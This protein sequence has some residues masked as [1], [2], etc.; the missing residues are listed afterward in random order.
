MGKF[1]IRALSGPIKGKSFSFRKGLKIG[2]SKGE[3]LLPDRLVSDLHAEIAF[4][5]KQF[6]IVDRG[7]KNKIFM[8]GKRLEKS[9]LQIGSKFKIGLTEF[10][11]EVQKSPEQI[12]LDFMKSNIDSIE[13]R[14][15]RLEPF[16]KALRLECVSGLDRGKEFLLLYGPRFFGSGSVEFPLFDESI[17]KKAFAF[18]PEGSKILFLSS[19]PEQVQLNNKQISQEELKDGDEISIEDNLFKVHLEL[20]NKA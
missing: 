5:G 18:V 2:R 11:L 4:S 20:L 16:S 13:D 3:V 17:P 14:P 1:I 6:V 8:N 9:A 7:S 15:I 19:H 10:K 12:W